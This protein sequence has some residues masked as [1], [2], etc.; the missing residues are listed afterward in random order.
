MNTA[1]PE[2]STTYKSSARLWI[3]IGALAPVL[4]LIVEHAPGAYTPSQETGVLMGKPT[5]LLVPVAVALAGVAGHRQGGFRTSVYW[6]A[7]A[8]ATAMATAGSSVWIYLRVVWGD[9]A[10]RMIEF[11]RPTLSA[12]GRDEAFIESFTSLQ[13]ENWRNGVV[14]LNRA[15]QT[16]TMGTLAFVATLAAT[17]T[18]SRL[19]RR[20][21]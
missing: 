11:T 18:R 3:G 1:L 19:R 4:G 9:F 15:G 6:M 21:T 20:S 10:V 7:A 13:A 8:V 16:L 5:A 17:W 12:M 14:V 2:S